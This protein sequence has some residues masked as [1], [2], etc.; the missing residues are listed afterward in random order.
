[1]FRVFGVFNQTG[2][3][4]HITVLKSLFESVA[5]V[6]QVNVHGPIYHPIIKLFHGTAISTIPI[7]REWGPRFFI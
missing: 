2:N 4:L 7:C 6:H 1:M 3:V 5:S